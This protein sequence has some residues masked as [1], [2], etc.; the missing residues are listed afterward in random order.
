V[1][2]S[3]PTVAVALCCL[4]QRLTVQAVLSLIV[5]STLTSALPQLPLAMG[6]EATLLALGSPAI[7][8]WTYPPYPLTGDLPSWS[9]RSVA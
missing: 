6:C 2:P 8:N 5:V 7:S 4:H 3:E 9:G 1:K